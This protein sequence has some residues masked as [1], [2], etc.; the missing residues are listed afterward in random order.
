M[1]KKTEHLTGK[2]E[3]N[4]QKNSTLLLK[5]ITHGNH[6]AYQRLMFFSYLRW[7][8]EYSTRFPELELGL[9]ELANMKLFGSTLVSVFTQI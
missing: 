6:L 8:Y 5:Y 9:N 7:E 1:V 3:K 2:P 4:V